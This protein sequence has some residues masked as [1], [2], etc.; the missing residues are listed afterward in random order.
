MIYLKRVFLFM[1]VGACFISCAPKPVDVPATKTIAPE[2]FSPK[3][4][5]PEATPRKSL[6]PGEFS[7]ECAAIADLAIQELSFSLDWQKAYSPVRVEHDYHEEFR[8]G[9]RLGG[10]LT[11]PGRIDVWLNSP[12]ERAWFPPYWY[13]TVASENTELDRTQR[14]FQIGHSSKRKKS[15]IVRLDANLDRDEY[16]SYSSI[17]QRGHCQAVVTFHSDKDG[18]DALLAKGIAVDL[19]ELADALEGAADQCLALCDGIPPSDPIVVDGVVPI[20]QTEQFLEANP[21]TIN[22]EMPPLLVSVD[23]NVNQ[24]ASTPLPKAIRGATIQIIDLNTEKTVKA[25]RLPADIGNMNVS[26]GNPLVIEDAFHEK[27]EYKIKVNWPGMAIP[28]YS[29]KTFVKEGDVSIELNIALGSIGNPRYYMSDFSLVRVQ[30]AAGDVKLLRNWTM[31]T[32]DVPAYIVHNESRKKIWGVGFSQGLGWLDDFNGVVEKLTPSEWAIL[33][34]D[35]QA[36]RFDGARSLEPGQVD[37]SS[38]LNFLHEASRFT[39]GKYRYRV[40]Y[41]YSKDETLLFTR[42]VEYDSNEPV[43]RYAEYFELTDVFEIPGEGN[44]K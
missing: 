23:D 13:S 28:E 18:Q 36:A 17:R 32:D 25:F 21:Q 31:N 29:L 33:N 44:E 24:A 20:C 11:I 6:T 8:H 26:K 1:V 38:E 42:D 2:A 14:Y 22:H 19:K 27:G 41:A 3:V 43:R 4:G 37:H 7:K 40:R 34:T 16:I 39:P 9:I 15:R 10:S 30:P 5:A 35:D 12:E